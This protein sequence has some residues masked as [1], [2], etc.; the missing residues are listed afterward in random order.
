MAAP[1]WRSSLTSVRWCTPYSLATTASDA[2][3][4]YRAA[5]RAT[6]SS[7]ILRT[8]RRRAMP[9]PSRQWVT[10]VRW[11]AYRRASP[12]IDAPLR[13][14]PISAST[15]SRR[16]RR[17]TGFESRP[18]S[19]GTPSP[20][21]P[22]ARFGPSSGVSRVPLDAR[23]PCPARVST[24]S[25]GFESCPSRS[26]RCQKYNVCAGQGTDRVSDRSGTFVFYFKPVRRRRS[27]DDTA[28]RA[29]NHS[30]ERHKPQVHATPR[31][32]WLV[33]SAKAPHPR[34][35]RRHPARTAPGASSLSTPTP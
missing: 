11:I 10:V 22:E 13:Y 2:P 8:T 21:G 5:A 26:T 6:D 3:C 30:P 18:L 27:G 25:S 7:V 24:L 28:D 17:C 16:S 33:A 1:A 23:D 35:P 9:A 34:M 31:E 14:R 19:S 12:S 15:S 29:K 20:D 32:A 4:S